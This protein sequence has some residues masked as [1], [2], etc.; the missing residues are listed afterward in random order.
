MKYLHLLRYVLVRHK[1]RINWSSCRIIMEYRR[2]F[3]FVALLLIL[4]VFLNS[5]MTAFCFCGS[6]C[7]HGLRPNVGKK[8]PIFLFHL[9]CPGTLCES[10]NLEKDQVPEAIISTIHPPCIKFLDFT[11][12]LSALLDYPSLDHTVKTLSPFY[13][14]QTIPSSAIY[15]Q[16]LSIRC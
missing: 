16:T 10:C 2:K 7:S 15:L 14:F 3:K 9:R 8:P 5:S 12:T 11:F 1:K 4:A 13:K 6:A